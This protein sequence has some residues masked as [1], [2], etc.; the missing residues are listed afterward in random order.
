MTVL[1]TGIPENE[2]LNLSRT[3]IHFLFLLASWEV[4]SPGDYI[5]KE[6]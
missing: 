5:T 1:K 6:K 4:H 3:A 2:S